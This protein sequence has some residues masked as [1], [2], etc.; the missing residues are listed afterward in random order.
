MSLAAPLCIKNQCL[1]H[2]VITVPYGDFSEDPALTI[3]ASLWRYMAEQSHGS[4]ANILIGVTLKSA[5]A[6]LAV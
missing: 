1:F 2:N 5:V 3:L 6:V 4:F